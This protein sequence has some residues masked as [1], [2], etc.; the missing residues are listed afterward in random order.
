M[1]KGGLIGGIGAQVPLRCIRCVLKG[2]SHGGN[3]TVTSDSNMSLESEMPK[4]KIR[5]NT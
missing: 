3:G 2:A 5:K 1:L 4:K